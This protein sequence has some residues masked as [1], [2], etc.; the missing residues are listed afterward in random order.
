MFIKKLE[1]KNIKSY[2]DSGEIL[3]TQGI[4][5][6]TGPNG[7]GKSTI[8]EA[9]GFTLFDAR[10]HKTENF[11][12]DG[13][14]RGE[15]IVTFIDSV[16]EREY[17]AIRPVGSGTPYIYDP[18]IKRKIV[19]GKDNYFA[20]LKEHMDI[21]ATANL[22]ALF[23]DAVGVPQGNLTAVFSDNTG[24]RKSKFDPLLQVDDYELTWNLLRP[25]VSH[26]ESQ[27]QSQDKEIASLS[28]RL[29]RLPDIQEEEKLLDKSVKRDE[30]ELKGVS[31][32]LKQVSEKKSS[33]DKLE[34]EV[35]DLKHQ[36]NTLESK[37]SGLGSQLK[38]AEK[39]G[40]E[41]ENAKA[42]IEEVK[43][44]H[45][46]Y[47]KA[48]A[49]LKELEKQLLER[50]KLKDKLAKSGKTIALSQQSIENLEE[51]LQQISEA[52]SL[53]AQL[54]P[55]VD[56]QEE[57]ENQ[58]K[59]LEKTIS[60]LEN[61]Q[62]RI[63]EEKER[64]NEQKGERERLIEKL[65]RLEENETQLKELENEHQKLIEREASIKTFLSQSNTRRTQIQERM[66]ILKQTEE[67]QCPVCQQ[68]LDDQHVH[69]LEHKY[70]QELE[71]IDQEEDEK[72]DEQSWIN[73]ELQRNIKQKTD[74]EKENRTLPS[75]ARE[76][77]I[78]DAIK[79]QEQIL[80]DWQERANAL[81]SVPDQKTEI[82]KKLE[83]IGDPKKDY[84][85]HKAKADERGRVEGKL[86]NK[87]NKLKA[88]KEEQKSLEEQLQPFANLDVEI[89]SQKQEMETHQKAHQAYLQ[90]IQTA[91]KLAE[92]QKKVSE[93]EE[94]IAR[95]LETKTGLVAEFKIT[96]SDY[97]ENEH[98]RIKKDF[99]N[100]SSK[101]AVLKERISINTENL[102]KLQNEI[103][104]LLPLIEEL[105]KAKDEFK[106]LQRLK[107]VLTFIRTVIREAGPHITKQHVR[108][109]SSEADKIYGDILNDYTARLNW[110]EEYEITI[111]Q[112][113]I[114]REF[115]Q[116][117]GGE[118]MAAAL[119]V[120]LALL[121]Y[122]SDISIAFFDE[123]TAH[124]DM[125]RRIN[126]AEQITHIKGFKQLFIISHDDTFERNIHHIIHIFKE[127]GVSQLEEGIHAAIS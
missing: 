84:A 50:D 101:E 11:I 106:L 71:D 5:A 17:Q 8:L 13:E 67:A 68:D 31:E 127:N 56:Q 104:K 69:D 36:I 122:M 75:R 3:F 41:A 60:D 79:K 49:A 94:E 62:K 92:R 80:S 51:Q 22:S 125:E 59:D 42:I 119:A 107:D 9:I 18:E 114:K 40:E 111:E 99:Q 2:E 85:V 4:N 123:P 20:W 7:A 10:A 117:S 89:S 45:K 81:S 124:L 87:K 43:D 38:D 1:L 98:Q 102:E 53:V 24:T 66:K 27:I 96:K 76:L 93:V 48:K 82:K 37:I 120:R 109:I 12:R 126:L 39:S 112:R 70:Q 110:G 28:A 58:L 74:L 77:E 64:L 21:S 95:N 23:K 97:D 63:V 52:E 115:S 32:K 16:D 100:L 108:I 33:L 47:E 86:E 73:S 103:G 26:L 72:R 78:E 65:Q 91:D 83:K 30:I 61:A 55:K 118:K 25:S 44:G 113:G 105:E 14:K 29:E 88:V 35:Q 19:N 90:N 57:L 34:K 15:I 54:K 46:A 121:Q 6:I 116:L